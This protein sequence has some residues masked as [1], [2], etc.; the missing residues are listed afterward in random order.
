MAKLASSESFAGFS[1]SFTLY[2]AVSSDR[3]EA[4]GMVEQHATSGNKSAH[5]T[6]EVK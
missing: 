4:A 6:V 2:H 5:E 1:G 3:S